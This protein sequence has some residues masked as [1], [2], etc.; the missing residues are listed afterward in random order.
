M[1]DYYHD[2]ERATREAANYLKQCTDAAAKIAAL[3]AQLAEA[4]EESSRLCLRNGELLQELGAARKDSERVD[5]LESSVV[6]EGLYAWPRYDPVSVNPESRFAWYTVDYSAG[7][8]EYLR[9]AIDA[10]MTA[11]AKPEG[12]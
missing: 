2:Y 5:W 1:K 4:N 7:P 9:A 3:E 11:P 10:A 12:R 6:V 8:F